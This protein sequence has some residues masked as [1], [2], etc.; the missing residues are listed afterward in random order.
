VTACRLTHIASNKH[1][2]IGNTHLTWAQFTD[3]DISTLQAAYAFKLLDRLSGH[4]ETPILFVGDF[5]SLNTHPAYQLCTDGY[6]NE[7]SIKTLQK[8]KTVTLPD[9]SKKAL[10]DLLWC[11]FKH[12]T[13]DVRSTYLTVQGCEPEVTSRNFLMNHSVDYMWYNQINPLSV[14]QVNKIEHNM[15]NIIY[16]SDHVSL[17]AK[18]TFL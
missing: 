2:V 5:N 9:G 18:Y 3:L 7:D 6:L 1:I 16:P 10:V 15:P 13:R 8:L 12:P 11:A 4:G 14:A 17:Q